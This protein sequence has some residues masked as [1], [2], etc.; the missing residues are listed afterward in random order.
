MS[1]ST[2]EDPGREHRDRWPEEGAA[3][4]VLEPQLLC[5]RFILGRTFFSKL[6][7]KK[8][9]EGSKTNCNPSELGNLGEIRK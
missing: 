4:Y 2:C 7:A 9:G 3:V 6:Y 1:Q 5:S 8:A